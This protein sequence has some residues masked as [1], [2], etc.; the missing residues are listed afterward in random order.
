M[1]VRRTLLRL[2]ATAGAPMF[3]MMR[4]LF[5]QKPTRIKQKEITRSWSKPLRAITRCRRGWDSRCEMRD[6]RKDGEDL[7]ISTGIRILDRFFSWRVVP[8]TASKGV[9]A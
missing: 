3:W 7:W 6:E 8:F 2:R 5:G 1:R 4:W 9:W